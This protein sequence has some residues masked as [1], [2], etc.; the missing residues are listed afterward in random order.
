MTV[1]A[2]ITEL[3][4]TTWIITL[5]SAGWDSMDTIVK[6]SYLIKP[7]YTKECCLW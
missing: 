7:L 3:A 1:L 6:V 5:V 4:T 2:L